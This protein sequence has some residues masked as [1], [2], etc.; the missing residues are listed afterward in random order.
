VLVFDLN[1]SVSGFRLNVSS[2][3]QSLPNN[4]GSYQSAPDI[5]FHNFRCFGF[6]T[7][8]QN[9]FQSFLRASRLLSAQ[10][11]AVSFPKLWLTLHLAFVMPGFSYP[12]DF[13]FHNFRRFRSFDF[14]SGFLLRIGTQ[15]AGVVSVQP[16]GIYLG[17]FR[18]FDNFGLFH[19]YHLWFWLLA[20]GS[21]YFPSVFSFSGKLLDC[22]HIHFSVPV[23]CSPGL[24]YNP[25]TFIITCFIST[26]ADSGLLA[27]FTVPSKYR[28]LPGLSSVQPCSFHLSVLRATHYLYYFR[29]RFQVSDFFTFR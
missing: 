16:H 24:R 21:H 22:L 13:P 19:R 1:I 6:S 29:N 18:N 27:N 9:S 10:P 14:L 7:F 5:P 12:P 25:P 8:L 4:R 20:A 23:S 11:S 15:I 28:L 2:S 26:C 3:S 17:S